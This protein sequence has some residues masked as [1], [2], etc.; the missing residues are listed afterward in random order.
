M[1]HQKHPVSMAQY[2]T[3]V[4][5]RQQQQ[6]SLVQQTVRLSLPPL[7]KYDRLALRNF[8]PLTSNDL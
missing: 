6:V 4:M 2:S 5:T 1:T 3:F 8:T 7:A